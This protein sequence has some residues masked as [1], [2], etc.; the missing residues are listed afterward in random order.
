ME[1]GKLSVEDL[2]HT[3]ELIGSCPFDGKKT[4][5]PYEHPVCQVPFPGPPE[6]HEIAGTLSIPFFITLHIQSLS[7]PL[8]VLVNPYRVLVNLDISSARRSGKL[9]KRHDR[10]FK[11]PV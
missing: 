3:D 4:L 5:S 6:T 1:V 8:N 11:L 7:K 2:S 9:D 10:H